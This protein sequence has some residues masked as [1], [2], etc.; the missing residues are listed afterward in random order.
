MCLRPCQM[1]VGPEEYA[2]EAARVKEFLLTRG[3]SLIETHEAARDRFSAEMEFEQAARQHKLLERIQTVLKLCD[4]L[5]A[6][7][8]QLCGV[9]VLPSAE[10]QCVDLLF[11]RNGQWL[12]VRHFAL[13]MADGQPVSLDKRLR[14][15]EA[16]LS[17]AEKIAAAEKQEHLAILARWYYS[18]WCD[19]AWV[20]YPISYRKLVGAVHRVAARVPITKH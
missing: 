10:P 12:P 7:A 9:A 18:S 3:A 8:G 17:A 13:V 2:T 19:G 11:M 14:E 15:E 6:D 1:V 4:E 5:A 20:P 16:S